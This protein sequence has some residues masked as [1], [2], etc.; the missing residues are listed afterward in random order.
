[1][2]DCCSSPG[3]ADV[4]PGKH[5]CPADGREYGQVSV[6][7]IKHHLHQSWN[8]KAKAQ[9]YYFCDAP[10]CEVVYFG[11]DDSVIEK[12]A[13]RTE[14]GV[15]LRTPD[16]LVCY[17]YGVSYAQAAALPEAKAFVIAET[18]RKAC[19]CDTRN[20]S[21]KCCLASFPKG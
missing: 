21:G 10:D 12:S 18:R 9:S 14:V 5:R 7:T 16:A 8:W 19:A 17:C 13:L 15:K 3:V 4:A 20:P 6:D 2:S 11:W 1:M